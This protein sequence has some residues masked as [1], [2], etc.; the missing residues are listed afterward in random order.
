M[1][2]YHNI[3][4]RV[5]SIIITGSDTFKRGDYTEVVHKGLRI[6][7]AISEFCYRYLR[8][9]RKKVKYST[10]CCCDTL[11]WLQKLG[12]SQVWQSILSHFVYQ[13]K[14]LLAPNKCHS[15]TWWT[16]HQITWPFQEELEIWIGMWNLPFKK[17]LETSS[18][19]KVYRCCGLNNW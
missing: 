7:T 17:M 3:I 15:R 19:E 2:I 12:R 13:G 1:A 9:F 8:Y 18:N 14:K 16:T 4:M 5:R 6:L 10:F 11:K